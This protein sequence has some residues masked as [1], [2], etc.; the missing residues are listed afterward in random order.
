MFDL[1]ESLEKR[2]SILEGKSK[3]IKS[4]KKINP[5]NTDKKHIR[6]SLTQAGILD[7]SGKLKSIKIG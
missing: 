2:L 4:N 7:K 6:A 1:Q 3:P 5:M